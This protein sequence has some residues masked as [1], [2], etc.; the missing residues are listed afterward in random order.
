MISYYVISLIGYALKGAK[1]VG[2]P[3]D[4]AVGM[5]ASVPLVVGVLWYAL[6]RL[7]TAH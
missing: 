6:R 7:K 3:L 4:P 5:A 2:S 1:A